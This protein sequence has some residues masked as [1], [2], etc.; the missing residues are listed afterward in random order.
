MEST[1]KNIF[2]AIIEFQ[3]DLKPIV[4][5]AENPFFKSRYTTLANIMETIQPLLAK[6]N[7]AVIQTMTHIEGQPALKT[8]I[9]HQSGESIEDTTPV[10]LVKNDPQS[11]GS[12]TTY[13]RRYALCSALGIVADEDDDGNAATHAPVKPVSKPVYNQ[14]PKPNPTS[15][16]AKPVSPAQLNFI[17]GLKE[18][19]GVTDEM[20]FNQGFDLMK[21]TGG[22]EGTASEL[23]DWLTKYKP[24]QSPELPVIDLSNDDWAG[25]EAMVAQATPF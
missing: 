22:K 20:I 1:T 15:T 19:K 5:D 16:P 9:I 10:Y 18:Q 3:S 25:V 17:N 2:N 12:T 8:S 23:I 13:M 4:K 7:L 21:L 6:H 24:N 14:S 11:H